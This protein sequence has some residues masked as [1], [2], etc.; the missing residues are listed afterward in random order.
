MEHHKVILG[1]LD[2]IIIVF[3]LL[4]SVGIGI[5]FRFAGQK[6]RTIDEYLLAGKNMTIFPV[7]FS[8]MASYISGVVVLG[9]PAEI[10]R[11]GTAFSFIII[12]AVVGT[13]LASVIFLPV[14]F[15]IQAP[16]TYE[17][18]E[19]RFGK[20]ARKLCSFAFVVQSVL[21]MAVVIYAPGLALNA[22]T[23]LSMWVSVVSITAVCT[24]YCAL[25]GMKAVLWTDV[26]Q[27]FLMFLCVIAVVIKGCIEV[28][29]LKSVFKIADEG[30]R[31]SVPGMKFDP[32]IRYTMINLFLYGMINSLSIYG[33]SQIQ[34]QRLLTIQNLSR[35]RK[36][37]YLNIPLMAVFAVLNCFIGVVLYAYYAKCNPMTSPEK[38]ISSADQLLPYF[39]MS[40]LSSHPGVAGLCIAGIFSASLSTVSSAINSLSAVTTEDL[41]RPYFRSNAF[42]ELKI[43]VFAKVVN[44]GT[45]RYGTFSAVFYG[46]LGLSLTFVVAKFGNLIQIALT[47]VT[48]INAP[49]CGVFFLGMMTRRTNEKG[50][51]IG[52]ICSIALALWISFRSAANGPRPKTLPVSV[53]GCSSNGTLNASLSLYDASSILDGYT[54]ESWSFSDNT[55]ASSTKTNDDVFYLYRISYVWFGALGF[56]SCIVIGYLSS[57]FFNCIFPTNKK[58]ISEDLLSPVLKLLERKRYRKEKE[59]FEM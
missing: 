20:L 15:Q 29:G 50:A 4:V 9:L 36:A 31:L 59:S 56:F 24:F 22:V 28:G 44:L 37:I 8:L 13:F 10:Y 33:T 48:F 42:S 40:T 18:L 16:T 53:E 6:Q 25:G 52:L 54:T 2:Y 43:A 38:P 17:Y 45:N 32:V 11:F 51:V 35:S 55:T 47:I 41:I 3:M 34:V 5:Y 49:I 7:A 39:I 19:R 30:E 57:I 27:V 23:N 26:F 1:T 46:L 12:G 21:F 58:V 14:F